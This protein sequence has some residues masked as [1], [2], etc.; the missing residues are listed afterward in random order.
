MQASE[1]KLSEV[2]LDASSKMHGLLAIW[3]CSTWTLEKNRGKR[4][5]LNTDDLARATGEESDSHRP[6]L[7]TSDTNPL[8][9]CNGLTGTDRLATANRGQSVDSLDAFLEDA[10]F[11]C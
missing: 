7:D 2:I 4:S 1:I 9:V 5:R 8:G 6:E 10:I 11:Q 3:A